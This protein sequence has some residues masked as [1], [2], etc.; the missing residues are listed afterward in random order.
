MKNIS[1]NITFEKWVDYKGKEFFKIQNTPNEEQIANGELVANNIYEVL[2]DQF[3]NEIDIEVGF[4]NSELNKKIFS[5]L[6]FENGDALKISS[7]KNSELFN[8]IKDNL[9]FDTLIWLFGDKNN[10][11]NIYVSYNSENKKQVLR[12]KYNKEIKKIEY[13]DFE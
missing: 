9:S 12:T 3:G 5:G 10:P 6:N 1:K 11:Q 7:S 4:L 8:Y 2:I 13:I